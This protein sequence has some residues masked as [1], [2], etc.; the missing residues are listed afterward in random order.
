ML[1]LKWGFDRPVFENTGKVS[2]GL[3]A[4]LNRVSLRNRDSPSRVVPHCMQK[5]KCKKNSIKIGKIECTV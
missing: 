4:V 5:L 3:L 2:W 1:I